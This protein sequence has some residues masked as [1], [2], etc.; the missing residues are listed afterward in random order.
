VAKLKK[1][2]EPIK[3]GKLEL[4]NRIVMPALNTKLGTEFGA[5]SDRMIAY[6]VAR[7]RG[8]VGLIIIENTCV[9]WP[10]GKAG[11]NPIRADEWKFAQG[12]HDLADAVHVYGARIATQLQHTGRQ[13]SSLTSAE[14][15]QLVAPS[16]IPC[17]PTGA[18]TPREL[19]VEEIEI[20]IGKFIMGATIT[21]VAGFDAVEIHGAHGYL[22]EQFMSPYTNQRT[23]EYGGDLEGRMKF[24]LKIIE[25]IRISVGPDFPIIYRLSGDEFVEGGLT[26]EDNKII[27]R[28]LEAAGVDAINVSA[29]I[30]ESPPWFSRIFPTMGMPEG[31]NVPL[32]QEIKKTV[33][34]PIIVAGKLGNPVLAEQVL[35]EGKADLI[36]MGRPL[37][38]DPELPR[39]AAEGRVKDIRPCIYCNEACAGNISR[40][41]S[42]ECVVNPALGRERE[43]K[44]EP[45]SVSKRVLVVG[46]GPAGM[47]AAGVAALRG[48]DVVLYEK[49][50]KLGGQLLAASVPQFKKPL[51]EL[52]EYLKNQVRELEVK[53]ELGEEVTPG[54]VR[55]LN[56]DVVILATG[57]SPLIPDISGVE[58]RNVVTAVQILQGKKEAGEK[59]VIIGGGQ[60]GSELALFLAEQGKKVSIVEI[61]YGISLDMNLFSRFYLL[62][63]LA[64]LGVEVLANTTAKEIT[65]KGVIALDTEGNRQSIKADTVVLA[66]GFR[67]NNG[68]GKKLKGK[69]TELYTIGDCASLGK[70]WGAI[71][72]AWRVARLI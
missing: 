20:L 7:A 16:A 10:V 50:R 6:F 12:L 59:V 14:G 63:K 45:A 25:G 23:D 34:I 56:P 42:I 37:L 36:A 30:Y 19:A 4:K 57:A 5:V 62:D 60:V 44:I 69:V 11:T 48:H 47:E 18:E 33:K 3:I 21:K 26:L 72:S 49:E 28:R 15:Q 35:K 41:W 67:S 71:H 65:D 53:V 61:L 2:F 13:G 55:E 39:K 17:L 58:G 66:T 43:Y 24:A 70:V 46:G 54:L 68:L 27:A 40:F 32:A 52:A 22:I 38:A 64:E 51:K 1:L 9:D 29:A 8:G 31:C